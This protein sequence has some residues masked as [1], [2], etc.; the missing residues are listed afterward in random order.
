MGVQ[1]DGL[2]RLRDLGAKWGSV[3]HGHTEGRKGVPRGFGGPWGG[4]SLCGPQTH[5]S[6]SPV[7]PRPSSA[8]WHRAPGSW[9][10]HRGNREQGGARGAGTPRAL[11]GTTSSPGHS[12]L[13]V[14]VL[15]TWISPRNSLCR[16]RMSLQ[17]MVSWKQSSGFL[18]MSTPPFRISVRG[19]EGGSA[20][21]QGGPAALW[22]L[23]LH[24][25]TQP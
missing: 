24:G 5:V 7:C 17:R 8:P 25:S 10:L 9:D 15:S 21:G 1:A 22:G 12:Q 11:P 13:R 6:G 3:E 23:P 4:Q 19:Q 20:W 18:S 14:R 2:G 16:W